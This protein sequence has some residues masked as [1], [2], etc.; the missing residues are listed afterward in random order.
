MQ[1]FIIKEATV[2]YK[3]KKTKKDL[4]KIRDPKHSAEFIQSIL[5]N[6]SQEH[7]VCLHLNGANMII[8]Y[9][10]V[11]S[12]LANLCQ[13]HPRE[14]FQGAL[15]QGSVSIIVAHNHPSTDLIPSH[16]DNDVT[17]RLKDASKILGINLIDHLIVSDKDG[18]Y[19]YKQETNILD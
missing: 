11:T 17:N 9:Q 5:P 3:T 6:N 18:F 2:K 4:T 12:G 19:S 16:S 15:L 13:V 14:V 7:F 8:S 10:I 1:T